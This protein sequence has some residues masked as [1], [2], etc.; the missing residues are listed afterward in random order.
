MAI[1]I[2]AHCYAIDLKNLVG[3]LTTISFVMEQQMKVQLQISLVGQL[4][5]QHQAL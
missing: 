4:T 2:L 5:K 3:R 1:F